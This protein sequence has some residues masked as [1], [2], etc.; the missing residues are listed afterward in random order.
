MKKYLIISLVVVIAI[1]AT[2][3]ATRSNKTA[4]TPTAPTKTYIALGDSIAAGVGLKDDSDSSA[5]NRTNQSYPNLLANQQHYKLTNLACSGATFLHGIL[6]SQ[7][8]NELAVTPQI[9]QLLTQPKPDLI[10]LTAGANDAGW[11]T[12]FAKCYSGTC[13]TAADTAAITASLEQVSA[14]LTAALARIESQYGSS[15]PPVVVTGYHQVFPASPP[16]DC[17][18][19]A[20][21]DTTEL[22][23]G[24]QLQQK[25]GDTIQKAS[26]G[27]SFA[28]YAAVDFSGHELCSAD[29]WVQGLTD[30]QPYHPT[31]AGQAAFAASIIK[32]LQDTGSAQ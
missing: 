26:A 16:A 24:R 8:V 25:I 9:D 15:A 10:T 4:D 2:F 31:A 3:L 1:T 30:R 27:F 14:E 22:A 17:T 6:G 28:R 5:C 20:G 32:A 18:D 13:G 7:D 11:T 19:L 21:I 12:I 29:P 23:W